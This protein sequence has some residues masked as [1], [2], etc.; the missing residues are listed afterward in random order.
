MQS[1]GSELQTRKSQIIKIR[2][3]K[4]QFNKHP[5]INGIDISIAKGERVAIL[6]PSGSGKTTLIRLMLGALTYDAG[7]V[8]IMGKKMPNRMLLG[9]I[10]YMPQN[11]ALYGEI[12]G[13][14]NLMF[15]GGLMGLK[16]AKLKDAIDEMLVLVDLQFEG[17]K[18]VRH[19]SGGMKKRLSLAVALLHDPEILLLD[20]PTVGIDPLLRQTVWEELK[21]LGTLGK[22]LVIT[23]HVM[24][25]AERCQR[26][27]LIHEGRK[28]ADGAV[29]K[30]KK[31]T[32][33][34]RLESIFLMTK[35]G[36]G[37]NQ[38]SQQNHQADD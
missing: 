4:K 30:L 22:T 2:N 19:Y 37:N 31:Q 16:G 28:I 23:T 3:L 10:G 27:A 29:D 18:V 5:V 11:D 8:I 36:G 33:D 12:S 17:R 6:G 15:F 35:G 25:E 1:P 34:G 14:D 38:Y 7:E 9:K 21:R 32:P 20:E 26:A 24:D 13:K